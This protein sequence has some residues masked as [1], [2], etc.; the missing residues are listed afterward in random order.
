MSRSLAPSARHRLNV[1]GPIASDGCPHAQ[2]TFAFST[3]SMRVLNHASSL[4]VSEGNV[5]DLVA[6]DRGE[7]NALSFINARSG[8]LTNS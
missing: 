3:Q 8:G 7:C 4:F 1:A 2:T 6:R 5:R